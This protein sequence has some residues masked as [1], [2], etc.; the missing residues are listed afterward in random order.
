[1]IYKERLLNLDDKFYQI[2]IYYIHVGKFEKI[3]IP[4]INVM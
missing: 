4:N 3:A 1:M 2:M